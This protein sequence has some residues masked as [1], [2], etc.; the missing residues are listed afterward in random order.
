[1]PLSAW[2]ERFK[3]VNLPPEG[4]VLLSATNDRDIREGSAPKL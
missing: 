2:K 4:T 3:F 1:V